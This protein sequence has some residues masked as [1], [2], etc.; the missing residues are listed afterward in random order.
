VTYLFYLIAILIRLMP[1]SYYSRTGKAGGPGSI[2]RLDYLIE[3]E[4]SI[5]LDLI[6]VHL[7][8]AQGTSGMIS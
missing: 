2:K 5:T 3:Y 8:L 6:L 7:S 4:R 1:C